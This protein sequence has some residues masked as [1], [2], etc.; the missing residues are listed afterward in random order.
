MEKENGS[1]AV[2]KIFTDEKDYNKC[3]LCDIICITKSSTTKGWMLQDKFS[4]AK[5][6]ADDISK[7]LHEKLQ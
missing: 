3:S 6:T 5:K 4:A 7:F 1:D 2:E